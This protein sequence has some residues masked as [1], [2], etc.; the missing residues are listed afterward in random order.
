MKY[1]SLYY[2]LL[3]LTISSLAFS[4]STKEGFKVF[5]NSAFLK[6]MLKMNSDLTIDHPSNSDFELYGPKGTEKWLKSLNVNYQPLPKIHKSLAAD[7]PTPSEIDQ[8]LINF[9]LKYPHLVTLIEIGRSH[10]N[11]PILAVKISDNPKL[12]ELEPEF[13]YIANM[14]GNEIVG[15]ELL[16]SLIEDLL[17]SYDEGDLQITNLINNT[18]IYIIPSMNP[19]G[20]N[21]RRRGN[22]K[23]KDLNRNFPDFST[24]DNTNSTRKRQ[25]ETV[26]IM[27][28]AAKRNF[29]LSANFHGG[30]E[31]VNYPWDT[32]P[33]HFPLYDLIVNFS[34]EYAK[35]IPSMFN[36]RGFD[37]G[38]TNGYDWYEVDGGMQDWSYNWHNDLQITI[39]LS[40]S[41]WPS[42]NR[43]P[44]Y[45]TKN[46]YSLIKYITQIHQG[47][48]FSFTDKDV[49][50]KVEIKTRKGK[51]VGTYG[52][53][54]GEFYKVLP[55]GDYEF[56]ISSKEKQF[57]PITFSAEVQADQLFNPNYKILLKSN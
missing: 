33:E 6:K 32:T 51:I 2:V 49:Q 21:K 50:G 27:N 10:K 52:F 43:I 39:E 22:N 37:E 5:E 42:Y 56:E 8:K 7:Y 14:H 53:T 24:A 34:K 30:T 16:V 3:S 12:D 23:Y 54:H 45:Y 46:K 41:K 26:A 9:Q 57:K 44:A 31:V 47:A 48:G 29:S 35:H 15:R 25:P 11:H 28:F 36:S 17:K 40:H 20:A 55:V 4:N 38:V 1:H 13:K 18:E 19:D